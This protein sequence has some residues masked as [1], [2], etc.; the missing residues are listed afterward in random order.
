[1]NTQHQSRPFAPGPRPTHHQF[2]QR[3]QMQTVR[4]NIPSN[5]PP[6]RPTSQTPTAAVYPPNQPIMM[7]MAPMPFPSPQTAQYYIP[8]YRHS[9]PQYVGPPQQYPVQPTGPSTFY[10]GPSPGDFSA[11]Y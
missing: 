9:A 5:N 3:T 11:P 4:P 10:A 2:F 1:M 6:I 8:Q 7:A